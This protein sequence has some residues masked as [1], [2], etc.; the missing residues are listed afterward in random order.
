MDTLLHTIEANWAVLLALVV[1]LSAASALL[2]AL[3]AIVWFFRQALKNIGDVHVSLAESHARRKEELLADGLYP[4][5]VEK[6]EAA[7]GPNVVDEIANALANK[8]LDVFWP[9]LRLSL[10]ITFFT[11]LVVF[12][13]VVVI[14]LLITQHH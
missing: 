13:L 4:E 9:N 7:L 2:P 11:N 8:R 10:L 12:I 14:S 3:G 6:I 5:L 1:S